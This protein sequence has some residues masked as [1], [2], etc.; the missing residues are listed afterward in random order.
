MISAIIPAF[1]E[2]STIAEV[3]TSVIGHPDVNEVIVVNDGSTDTTEARARE[4]GAKVIT[5]TKNKGKGES[6]EVGVRSAKNDI[7][8]FMDADVTGFTHEKIS[9]IINPV[10]NGRYKMF[11]GVRAR[12][13]IFFNRY[14]RLFPI[15]SGERALVKSLWYEVPLNDKRGFKIEIALNYASKQT[16]LGM[17]FTLIGGIKHL[18][19]EKKYKFFDGF[20]RRIYM[21]FDVLSISIKLYVIKPFLKKVDR[22]LRTLNA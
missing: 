8:L 18:I 5:L 1:N 15:L 11:V 6:M 21:I 3:V 4:A 19:K 2:E 13:I 10:I 22:V 12:S 16:D 17:G 14:F 9:R 20:S 7:I